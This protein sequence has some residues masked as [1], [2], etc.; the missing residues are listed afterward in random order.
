MMKNVIVIGGGD[1]HNA[2]GV[3]RA[4][5]E[6]GYY[7]EFISIGSHKD[8]YVSSSR[9]VSSHYHLNDVRQL[10]SYLLYRKSK[11]ASAREILISCADS[12]TEHLNQFQDRLLDMYYIP[13]VPKQG[14]LSD[15]MDKTYMVSVAEKHGLQSPK[16]WAYPQD[17]GGIKYPCITKSVISSHGSKSDIRIC[18][19]SEQLDDFISDNAS[20]VFVQD[21]IVKKEEVQFIGCSLNGGEEV[22]IPGMS[23]IIRSQPNTNTGFLEYGPLDPFYEDVVRRAKDI[24]RDFRYSGLFSFEVVR[25][26]DDQVWFLEVNFR[27]DGNACCV[28]KAGINLPLIW[29][30]ACLGE[31]YCDEIKHPRQIKVMPEFQDFKL[32]LQ[33]KVSLRQWIADWKRTDSFMEYD[34]KD[35]RPF[36]AYL[37]RKIF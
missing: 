23:R 4:L 37:F 33:R 13:G 32:V 3:I 14:S 22:V 10:S 17:A 15:A 30:K 27:N 6:R 2:L 11:G 1:H 36:F 35:I 9:Y 29:V 24:M 18:H 20:G 5:G 31:S 8:D 7:V 28:Y 34:R 25:G 16:I 21:F 12:V 19:T 26:T